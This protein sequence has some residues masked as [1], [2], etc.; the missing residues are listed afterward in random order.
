[1]TYSFNGKLKFIAGVLCILSFSVLMTYAQNQPRGGE[2]PTPPHGHGS[3]GWKRTFIDQFNGATLNSCWKNSYTSN[4]H[5]LEGNK[6]AE[7][8]A[9]PGEGTGFNPFHLHRGILSIAA[10]P[11]P[12]NA[13]MQKRYPYLSGMI[14]SDG[15]F[16]QTYGY[17]EIRAR[18]PEGKGLWPA[19][20][21]LPVS[22]KWPPEIDV[23]EM[24]G[25]PNSR[26][27]GG[28]GW[29]HTGTVGAGE[30]SFNDWHHLD[31]DQYRQFHR[32]GVL[33]GPERI[34]IYVDGSLVTSEKTPANYHQPMYFIANLAVG[35]EWPELPDAATHF[36]AKMEIDSI[37]AW[38]FHSWEEPGVPSQHQ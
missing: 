21:L 6:E 35:G 24:F 33:W 18:V 36:P 37:E 20:W 1:M 17:F 8:Y 4:I 12:E 7:W 9:I 3:S 30:K 16:S 5:T 29:V 2:T 32:Y 13:Q 28:P 19:F 26:K 22:H 25:A 34:S 23:F 10:V 15:C 31:I 11:T 38:Q 27:E 14:M